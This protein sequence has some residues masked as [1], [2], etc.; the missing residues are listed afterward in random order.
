M[1]LALFLKP[2]VLASMDFFH[3]LPTHQDLGPDESFGRGRFSLVSSL[4]SIAQPTPNVKQ[5]VA[6]S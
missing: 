4:K 2:R 6:F 5:F 1:L 3:G